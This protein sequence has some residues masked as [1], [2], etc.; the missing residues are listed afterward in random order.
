MK[1]HDTTNFICFKWGD[2]YGPEYVNRLERSINKYYW[3]SYKFHCITD[4]A[5]GINSSFVNV[6]WNDDWAKMLDTKIF[7]AIKLRA[8]KTFIYDNNVILDL[9]ILIH[10]DITEMVEA[11]PTKKPMFIWTHWTPKWHWDKL[12][13]KKTACFINSSF[14]RWHDD[15]GVYL[16]EDFVT[17]WPELEAE[18]NSLDKFL[19]YEHVREGNGLYFWE[20][21]HFYNYNEPGPWQ[22]KLNP[23][24]AACL[25]NTSHLVKLGRR[26]YELD[27]TPTEHTDIWESYV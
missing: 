20:D 17:R 4:N 18:Y 24:A 6:I 27:N 13:E 26:H 11:P 15:T 16:Y 22:Y 5:E 14:V 19:F 3:G 9:D 8:M 1:Q 25:F 10:N 7:T 2:K 21:K 12:I 23:D